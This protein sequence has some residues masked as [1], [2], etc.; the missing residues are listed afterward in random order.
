[1]SLVIAIFSFI[2]VLDISRAG[3]KRK[4]SGQENLLFFGDISKFG[5]E[6]YREEVSHFVKGS[7]SDLDGMKVN[8]IVVN[9]RIVYY[10][11]QVFNIAGW[12]AITAFITPIFSVA[13]YC[14][15][16]VVEDRNAS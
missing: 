4:K 12:L 7:L 8:Q 11:M 16:R 10:K 6:E 9:S 13:T 1:L 14:I 5:F 3:L 2:P 15:L